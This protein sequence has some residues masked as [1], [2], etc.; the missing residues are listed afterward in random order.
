RRPAGRRQPGGDFLP[1]H[2]RRRAGGCHGSP[3]AMI[4]ALFYLQYHSVRNRLLSRFKRLKQP[5]YL[6]GALVGGLYFYFYFFRY[7]FS[8]GGFN[9]GTALPPGHPELVELFGALFL[10]V[11][12]VMAWIFPHERAALTF[13]EAEVAFLFPAPVTRRQL[14]HYKLIR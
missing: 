11:I 14:I 5:K 2:Q 1:R 9:Q 7:L 8:Q 13:T 6:V 10:F 3:P 12:V 4:A